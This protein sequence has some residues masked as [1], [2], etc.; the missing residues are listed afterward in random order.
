MQYILMYLRAHNAIKGNNT[1]EC[2]GNVFISYFRLLAKFFI[3]FYVPLIKS[4]EMQHVSAISFPAKWGW[5]RRP[6]VSH[7]GGLP[8][9]RRRGRRWACMRNLYNFIHFKK[10]IKITAVHHGTNA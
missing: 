2:G 1:E 7:W 3:C 9:P 5:I 4:L 10:L 6:N 8:L